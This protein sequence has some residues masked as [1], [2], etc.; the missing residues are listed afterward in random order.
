MA[1]LNGFDAE[2]HDPMEDFSV[3]PAGEYVAMA[4]DSEMR[5]TK[6]GTGEFLQITWEIIDGENQGRK[7]WS[8]LN[9]NN[10]NPTAVEI[11][12]REL[13]SICRAVNVLRPKNSEQLHNL[14]LVL[15]V[16]IEKR[17]DNGELANRVKGYSSVGDMPPR[18][19][20]TS[21]KTAA[22]DPPPPPWKR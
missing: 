10:P 8:R 16:G 7:L 15:N 22:Q 5:V 12:N 20:P 17:K 11:A 19:A 14:P 2:Q 3:M 4:M 13:S 1:E 9:L 18:S 6:L 21:E